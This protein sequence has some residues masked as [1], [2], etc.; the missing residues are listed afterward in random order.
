MK[1]K[2]TLIVTPFLSVFAMAA[3]FSACPAFAQESH[4]VSQNVEVAILEDLTAAIPQNASMS[5]TSSTTSSN[6][7]W[8]PLSPQAVDFR[9]NVKDILFAFDKYEDPTNKTTLEADAAYL[10][11]HPDIKVRIDGY[12]D[13]RGTIVYNL[14]LAQKR[15]DIARADLIRAGVSPDRIMSATGWGMLYPTCDMD[16]DQCWDVNRRAHLRFYW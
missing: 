13:N 4:A 5:Q 8:P 3:V 7:F 16:S 9:A 11:A 2:P 10:K 6:T 14:A 12:A 15:A 1:P